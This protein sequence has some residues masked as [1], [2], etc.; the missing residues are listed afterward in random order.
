MISCTAALLMESHEE[1]VMGT[2][3]GIQKRPEES[4]RRRRHSSYHPMPWAVE[5]DNIHVMV[6]S[7]GASASNYAHVDIS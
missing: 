3:S 5:P 7:S 2:T 4:L 6:Q 1:P